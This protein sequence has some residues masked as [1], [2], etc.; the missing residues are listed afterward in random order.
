[1]RIYD[2]AHDMIRLSGLEPGQD[3][4]VA[5]T[6][7]RPGEKLFEEL[8]YR[9]EDVGPTEQDKL[10]VARRPADTPYITLLPHL[11]ELEELAM[12]RERLSLVQLLR[13]V[14]PEYEPLTSELLVR[15][16][17]LVADDDVLVRDGI[18]RV[19]K[20]HYDVIHA[21]DGVEGLAAARNALP[22]LVLLD[23]KMPRVDG[24]SMCQALKAD[25]RTCRMPIIMLTGLGDAAEKV[26]G[27]GMGADDYI[28]KPFD[29]EELK[30]RI[31]MVLR[32][33]YG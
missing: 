20:E 23:L 17:I 14:V 11:T 1:V 29:A 30:A 27:I 6:G 12:V 8:W 19:L 3:I 4:D 15:R 10:L 33:A 22:D 31:Q 5:I 7:L 18:E 24:F 16:K 25:A 32:R 2:M 13:K 9:E 28:T 21:V 26:R